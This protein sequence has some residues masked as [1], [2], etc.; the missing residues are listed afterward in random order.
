MANNPVEPAQVSAYLDNTLD[1]AWPDAPPLDERMI[2]REIREYNKS[3]KRDRQPIVDVK[4]TV[5]P[6]VQHASQV[7]GEHDRHQDRTR[8]AARRLATSPDMASS[9]FWQRA[10]ERAIAE[11][12]IVADPEELQKRAFVHYAEAR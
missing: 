5:P 11:L 10:V 6:M 2:P 1:R 4:V 12:G 7:S 9:P 8:I 3:V